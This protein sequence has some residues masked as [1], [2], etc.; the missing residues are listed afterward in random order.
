ME[1]YLCCCRKALSIPWN[2]ESDS[3]DK[4]TM[5]AVDYEAKLAD[6][7]TQAQPDWPRATCQYGWEY[8]HSEIPYTTIA[9]EVRKLNKLINRT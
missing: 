9:T 7:L 5:Y 2:V 8:D 4:C 1:C 3:F 6:G